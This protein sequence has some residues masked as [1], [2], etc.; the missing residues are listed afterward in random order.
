MGL[1][2]QDLDGDGRPDLV[3][4]N[5]ANEPNSIYRNLEGAVFEQADRQAFGGAEDPPFPVPKWGIVAID[6]DDD[7]R[8]DLAIS[9]GQILSRLWTVVS[10]WFNPIAKNFGVGEKSYAQRQFLFRNE[11]TPG[12]IRFRDMSAVAGDLGR[13]VIVGRGLSAGDLDGDGRLDLAFNPIDRPAIILRNQARGGK[14][15]EILPVAGADRKTVLGTRVTVN[16]R[17]KEF[18]VVPS[19]ASGSWTPLHFGIGEKSAALVTVK[20]PDGTT[21]ELGTVAAG[22]YRLKKGSLLEP[23]RKAGRKAA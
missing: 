10:T 20:W 3:V 15:L 14:S 23:L 17:M 9:G 19:Y 11:S 2:A 22:A 8:D 6:Y 4:T 5:F 13:L 16:G 7:G 1:V 12:T 18:Y 21:E